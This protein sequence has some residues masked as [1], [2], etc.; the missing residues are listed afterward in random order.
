MR[1]DRLS[2]RESRDVVTVKVQLSKMD[3]D[4]I[5]SSHTRVRGS[6]AAIDEENFD[7]NP[8]AESKNAGDQHEQNKTQFAK[9][10][11]Y[12]N[13]DVRFTVKVPKKKVD[14]IEDIIDDEVDNALD[15][16]EDHSS[17]D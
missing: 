14:D 9:T 17:K 12:K 10:T 5:M 6:M 4:R 16:I 8:S 2:R 13:G 15:F 7:F 1:K 3:Y 11:L